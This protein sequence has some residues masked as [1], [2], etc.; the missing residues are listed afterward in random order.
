MMNR[1]RFLWFTIGVFAE[2]LWRAV[3][4]ILFGS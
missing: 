3:A 1:E 2:A 4:P